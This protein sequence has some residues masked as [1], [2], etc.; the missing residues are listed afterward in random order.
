MEICRTPFHQPIAD[1]SLVFSKLGV[2]LAV[3]SPG[4]RCAPIT[5]SFVRNPQIKC[6]TLSDERSAAFAALGMAQ[7]TNSSVVLVCTSG[8]ALLNYAPAI[9]EAYF[10]QVPL[11][12]LTADRPPEWIGQADGQAI[13]QNGVYGLH[14]K[15]NY[16]IP[17]DYNHPD[18]HWHTQRLASE[19]F[20]ACNAFPQGPVHLNIPI[21][22]P[23]YTEG[24]PKMTLSA[25][26][27]II[28]E[29]QAVPVLP[30]KMRTSIEQFAAQYNKILFVGG[31]ERYYPDRNNILNSFPYP[32]VCDVVSNLHRGV[33]SAIFHQD[34]FLANLDKKNA[35]QL[36]PDWL[37]TFG[38]SMISKNLK[39]FLRKYKPPAHW[40]IQENGSVA[41]TF[42]ALTQI[43]RTT[44][45]V[46]LS[47]FYEVIPKHTHNNYQKAWQAADKQSRKHIETV[48]K[49]TGFSEFSVVKLL[50]K[51]M[52]KG[53]NL[54]LANSMVVRYANFLGIEGKQVEVF[55]NRGTSGIDGS[56]STAVGHTLAKPETLNLLLTGDLSFFYDRN[57][58]WHKYPLKN[59]K[60][61]LINNYG[62]IIFKIIDGA[63]TLEE[64]PEYFQTEQSSE[65][66]HLAAEY[67]FS[68]R[69]TQSA[70]QFEADLSW[71][72]TSENPSLW[73]VCPE[74]SESLRA[75]D[76]LKKGVLSA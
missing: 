72:W 68:Y 49:A 25:K 66:K 40:H 9:A 36:R 67:S 53:I 12:V 41:D 4:S 37:I 43:V 15:K 70:E 8:T 10:S 2:S 56:N 23:V 69:K 46:F 22:E 44:P 52:P 16:Q 47:A 29:T 32:V 28:A 57:A 38:R 21:R 64:T 33:S 11:L 7:Q 14:T 65:A 34:L 55:S 60:I 45:D 20:H 5:L 63:K 30:P 75:V 73:E 24:T 31:Q 61:V 74:I 1:I 6:Y 19:A 59:L 54:H 17:T 13:F 76:L 58:F 48:G 51:S 26:V 18:A 27:K 42:Q 71:F 35:E 50:L 39:L 62:G 3:L